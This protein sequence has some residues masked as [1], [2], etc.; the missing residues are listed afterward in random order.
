MLSFKVSIHME[1]GFPVITKTIPQQ[2]NKGSNTSNNSM[3]QE[4]VIRVPPRPDIVSYVTNGDLL[5][6]LY[7]SLPHDFSVM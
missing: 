5:K 2:R 6:E 1:G 3:E 7:D 4:S